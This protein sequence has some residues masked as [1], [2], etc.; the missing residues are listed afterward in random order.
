MSGV[1]AAV[2]VKGFSGA[3]QRLSGLL[4]PSQ[5]AELAAAMLSDVL[6]ALGGTPLAGVLVN[7]ADHG[8]ATLARRHGARV[9]AEA[10]QEGHT[11]AVTAM[12]RVLAADGVEAMLSIPGDLPLVTA[13]ELA[14]LCGAAPCAPSFAIA[15]AHDD[16][17]SNA[18]LLK[19]PEL[20]PLRFGD[21]SFL[22][23]LAAARALGLEPVVVRLPGIALDIDHPADLHA[24]LR[25]SAGRQSASTMLVRR[26]LSD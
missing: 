21:D 20:M 3:K 7:T 15:P 25:S 9:I 10:A 5:R 12:A 22:P 14:D 6:T 19:P 18:V 24:L 23:H 11:A 16:R 13:D 4:S 17:G 2:P 1:W 8:A 26:W